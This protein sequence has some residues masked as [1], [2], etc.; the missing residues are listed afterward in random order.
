MREVPLGWVQID[1]V[2]HCNGDVS[3]DYIHTL[4]M[5]DY[6]TGWSQSRACINR[7]Q[8]HVHATLCESMSDFP[9]EIVHFHYDNGSEFLNDQMLRFCNLKNIEY[10]RSRPY[11]KEDNFFVENRNGHLI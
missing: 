6:R 8:I 2:H 3:G 1:L 9:F 10:S 11:K 4:E 7:A 5:V